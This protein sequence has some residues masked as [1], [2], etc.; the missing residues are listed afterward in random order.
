MNIK[1]VKA[2][3]GILGALFIV[4]P[5]FAGDVQPTAAPGAHSTYS[6]ED[7][8][9]R[10]DNGAPGSQ[11]T[12]NDQDYG[13]ATG[14]KTINEVM[15]A[16]PVLENPDTAAAE[17]GDV[18]SGK[19]FWGLKTGSWG[20]LKGTAMTGVQATG[21]A[22]ECFQ[23]TDPLDITASAEHVRV[24]CNDL[25][26]PNGVHVGQDGQ[27]QKGS[28][29]PAGTSPRFIIKTRTGDNTLTRGIVIDDLTG[30]VWTRQVNCRI[31]AL[32]SYTGVSGDIKWEHALEAAR[33]VAQGEC[34]GALMDGSAA[35]DW[36]VP[37]I[38][39]LLTLVDFSGN[40]ATTAYY[41]NPDPDGSPDKLPLAQCQSGVSNRPG[42]TPPSGRTTCQEIR[43]ATQLLGIYP[44]LNIGSA[45]KLWSSTTTAQNPNSAW[46]VSLDM[47]ATVLTVENKN[48]YSSYIFV[49]DK[50][51]ADDQ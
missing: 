32:S 41:T 20:R 50:I 11:K 48:R 10:L 45:T 8:Y 3:T 43:E 24:E 1:I 49:R 36:R 39:E 47:G 7:I 37:N 19:Y 42:D 35:D 9:N 40:D 46:Q 38:R 18:A 51:A 44:F 12:V 23:K 31:R 13:P 15:G 25:G 14:G 21:W 27:L 30:L 16:A 6:L 5:V 4:S 33:Y 28:R 34:G 22:N 2:M 29:Y 26:G 17:P